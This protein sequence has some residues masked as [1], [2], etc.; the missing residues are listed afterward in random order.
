MTTLGRLRLPARPLRLPIAA[1]IMLLLTLA[2]AGVRPSVA[3][4]AAPVATRTL[5]N[6][7]TVVV[8]ERPNALA[9]G[10]T[11]A[12]RA[13]T[14]DD[15][16]ERGGETALLARALAGGTTARPSTDDLTA[17]IRA[18]GGGFGFDIDPDLTTFTV[19]IPAGDL[20]VVV[21]LDPLA[22][23]LLHPLF[24]A[25]DVDQ[26]VFE[27]R[28]GRYTEPGNDLTTSLWPSH[29]AGGRP[30]EALAD[31]RVD[32]LLSLR[33]RLYGARN[34][35]IAV[36]GP[37][38]SED[39][40]ARVEERFGE[41]AAG[42]RRPIQPFLPD[43]PRAARRVTAARSEEQ[44]RVLMA[45]P[46]AG[47]GS[48]DYPALV[49]LGLLLNGPDGLVSLDVR[50]ERGLARDVDTLQLTY[51]DVGAIIAGAAVQPGNVEPTI[52]RFAG[53]FE[54]LRTTRVSDDTL[55][56]LRERFAG[57]SVLARERAR[58]RAAE[59]ARTTLLGLPSDD[60]AIMAALAAVTPADLQR[61]AARY[62]TP[63]RAIVRISSPE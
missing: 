14:R 9:I 56:R 21:A 31:L 46:T 8:E 40:F 50:S 63:D 15:A 18:V 26:A 57:E 36:V 3:P 61:V 32:D 24:E 48:P 54:R 41:L 58:A 38:Q 17:G 34:L 20:G 42:E 52:A 47:R 39:V 37:V 12:A 28:L 43:E 13:G 29:P 44:A 23:M 60:G 33:E 16:P 2:L 51:S 19:L 49:L 45:F 53:V 4:A 10:V 62:L 22:D 27:T 30:T 55:Q 6:G 5:A 7:L 25:R 1:I 59:L 35:V 11:L